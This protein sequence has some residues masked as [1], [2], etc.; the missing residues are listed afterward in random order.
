MDTVFLSIIYLKK[1]ILKRKSSF[2]F[3]FFFHF[4]LFI[5]IIVINVNTINEAKTCNGAKTELNSVD[6]S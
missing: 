6:G 2:F 4:F 1:E 5:K 3:Y